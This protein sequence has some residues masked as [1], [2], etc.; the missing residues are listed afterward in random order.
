MARKRKTKTTRRPK[1]RATTRRARRPV[2]RRNPK[3][4]MD[5]PA[6]KYGGIAVGGAAVGQY[7][8]SNTQVAEA[9]APLTFDGKIQVAT[10]AGILTIALAW[11]GLKGKNRAMALALGAGMTVP[12]VLAQVSEIGQSNDPL[13]FTRKSR[14]SALRAPKGYRRGAPSKTHAAIAKRSANVLQ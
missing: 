11:F 2:A 10:V 13:H 14:S 4:L 12:Q 5:Q 9:L 1:R 7:V 6:L 3:G 8:N